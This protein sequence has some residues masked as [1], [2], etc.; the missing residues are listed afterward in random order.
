VTQHD[1]LVIGLDGF[2][3][4]YGGP[5]MDAGELPELAA[6]RERSARFL[7]DHGAATR[8]GLAWDHFATGMTPERAKRA[9]GVDLVGGSYGAVQQGTRFTPF[10]DGLDR[11]VVV[12]DPP[13]T[14][15]SGAGGARGVVS[16][17]A[18]DPG[19]SA[20][21]NPPR[22]RHELDRR[23]GPYPSSDWTY[24]SPWPS[25]ELTA[26]MG[27]QL[28]RGVTARSEAARW[29]LTE[30]LPDWDLAIVVAGEPHS[31]AEAF[32]HGVDA[33][34]PLHGLPSAA[35]AA[36]GLAIVYRACDRF[37]G[38]LI[39]ATEPRAVLVFSMGGMG[40]NKSDT[41]SMALLPELVYRWA[42]GNRLLEVPPEW[43][44]PATVPILPAGQTWRDALLACY[45]ESSRP[46]RPGPRSRL[47]TMARKLWRTVHGSSSS[48]FTRSVDWMPASRYRSEWATMRAFAIPSFYDGR[49]RVNLRGRE[50]AGIVDPSEYER[51]CDE[52]ESMLWACRDP[53]TGDPVVDHVSRPGASEPMTLD[54]A[55]A[56]IVVTWRGLAFGLV[57]PDLGLVGPL[58]MRRTG[59]HTGPHGFAFASRAGI[60]AGD[61]GVRSSFDVSPTVAAMLDLAPP[62]GIDG[63]SLLGHPA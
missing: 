21:S 37:V 47:P 22:L 29:V 15:I 58:P 10:F 23:F 13:Y 4:G 50:S 45:P 40:S 38:E 1:L 43:A 26:E 2:D 46:S 53:R 63:T 19:V 39:R 33:T 17:G 11:Q 54:A 16:W 31:A 12:F 7:L 36:Q 60:E 41:P 25:A 44:G 5:L 32:W 20:T 48:R 18:H 6:L 9:S 8:T 56:D 30:R 52:L 57:H 62:A 42:T 34:H 55:D 27:L 49:I 3:I 51:T 24:V 61:R 35:S 14:D 28:V 59:G